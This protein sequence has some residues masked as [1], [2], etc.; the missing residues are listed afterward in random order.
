MSKGRITQALRCQEQFKKYKE[1]LDDVGR[2]EVINYKREK[3]AE[4]MQTRE[5]VEEQIQAWNNT[6]KGMYK[7]KHVGAREETMK[8]M[9]NVQNKDRPSEIDSEMQIASI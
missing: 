3:F 4:L 9:R 8:M 1:Q 7:I 5:Q 2:K 6:M